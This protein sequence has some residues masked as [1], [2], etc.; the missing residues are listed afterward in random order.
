MNKRFFFTLISFVAII[1]CSLNAT[2]F[3]STKYSNTSKLATK[4]WVKISIPENGMYQI[5]F[6]ELKDM[7]FSDPK[8]VRI[9]GYG[10][11]PLSELLDGN[12]LD[13]LQQIPIKI[14]QDKIYFYG[15][16]PVKHS[17][18]SPATTPQYSR[19]F[20]SY[21]TMG[22]YFITS[23]QTTPRKEPNNVTYQI[24]GTNVRSTSLDYLYHE[25]DLV[26]PSQ[27]GKEMLGELITDNGITI[28]YS[29]Y[30]LCTDS[31]LV[32]TPSVAAKC[33]ITTYISAEINGDDV[34]LSIGS[35]KIYGSTSQY[36]FY[37]TANP[38]GIYRKDSGIPE[39]GFLK[40]NI[41]S[42][43][44]WARL[45]YFIL[46]YYH[47]NDIEGCDDNQMRLG[48]NNV[49]A[50]DIL[51]VANTSNNIQVWNIDNPQEPKNYNLTN[52]GDNLMGFTPPAAVNYSQFIAFNPDK[53][54]KSIAGFE[55]IEN[56]NIH[57]LATPDMIIVT[58]K[59]LLPQAERIAQ[60]HRDKDNMTVHV[61]DQ[62][63]IFNEFSS[64]TP[65]AMAIR[66]MCKMFY[67]RDSAK[68]KHLLML[69]AGS[70]DNRQILSKN[71]CAILTYESNVSH[72]ENN[73]Y[74]SDDFFGMLDDNSGINIAAD[75][76]RL[77]VGRI[78][79]NSVEEAQGDVDKL[80]NYVNNPDYGPW[81]NNILLTADYLVDDK[82]IHAYQAEG[83]GNIITDELN[84]G[85]MKNKVYVSQFQT[86][87]ISGFCYDGR[88]KMNSLLK[89]GQYFMTYV[90]H[91]NG[92]ALT[93]EVN[94]WTTNE[95]KKAAYPHLPII[96]TACCDVARFDSNQ[97]GLME[98]MFHKPDGGAIAMM[99]AT[100]AA[101]S[102][103][104][105][106]LN[107]AF[108]RAAFSYNTTGYMPTLG[109]AYMQSKNSFGSSTN[110]N[111]MM[112]SLLG[113][114]A[115]KLNYPKPLFKVTSINGHTVGTSGISTGALQQVTIVAKVYS[116][117]GS[118]VDY[119]FN[120]NATLTI[121]DLLKK[122]RTYENR[123]I[124]FP[125]DI[126]NQ[127]NGR[128]VNGVFT[129]KVVIPRHTLY[130]GNYGLVSVYAHRDN[131]EEMVNGSFD[132]LMLNAY[133][134]N[135][136]L[137]INDN[138]PP[139]IE[140][141]YFNDELDFDMCNQVGTNAT[142]HI[143]AT[144]NYS[145]NNQTVS[146]GNSMDLKLDGGKTSIPDVKVYATMTNEGKTL[147]VAMPMTLEP[148]NH[149]L[150]YTVYDAAGNVTTQ[151]LNFGVGT[152]QLE[153]T[154]D[155]EPAVDEATFNV[156]TEMSSIPEVNIK[157]F[158]HTGNLRWQT[159]TK[160]FP[161]NWNLIGSNGKRLPAGI[162][163][164]YGKYNDGTNYGGTKIGTLIVA[165]E[166][167]SK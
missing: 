24:T 128:V 9:F 110:Y 12:A 17:V 151:T 5:T 72:D 130:P 22:Y 161:I 53:P 34:D 42:S 115:I 138:I 152:Q 99:A 104:N 100:R 92:T 144:D 103:G 30:G 11:N 67:D 16:G 117:D 140:A 75:I 111:K 86:D 82:H 146:V 131:S 163:T 74:V 65:D 25:Q 112:F 139:T 52:Y 6:N 44:T 83:I 27:S 79:C 90:G 87:P 142:L 80:I 51:A 7:G 133:N 108:V 114:P 2:A 48:F 28:P 19:D 102:N 69:G 118:H 135:N 78:P 84:V 106:A 23:D 132:K 165:D 113:D 31:A 122:E 8:S 164:F 10:G 33:E 107:Q 143:H 61:L 43:V 136:S 129:C 98:I 77:G 37:N 150:H 73:S 167:K 155:Q 148:G 71:D 141:I 14:Y 66:L 56:Q 85:V 105:D 47:H 1:A 109:E 124:Y 127:V 134:A 50:N 97:R 149:T 162:Y 54:L 45:N 116:P 46:T 154:V 101:Y 166:H 160:T 62:Q 95:S 58:C 81:R 39:N 157:V 15:R 55:S 153:L 38:S 88:K 123:D 125:R 94:M 29:L 126:V 36:V 120:G 64:G 147:D 159:T 89:S 20:N 145:F 13:D 91:A 18:V 60:M 3:P 63:K 21:S 49:T 137:T 40:L 158:N 96:T 35:S 32:I 4:N 41:S 68:F 121:Y 76:L 119:S 26:S 57:G 70:F 156:T 59:S 93:K